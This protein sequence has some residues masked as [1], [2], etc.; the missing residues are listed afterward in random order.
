MRLSVVIPCYRSEGTLPTVVERLLT[1]LGDPTAAPEVTAFEVILVVDGS[2]DETAEVARA[3]SREHSMVRAVEL[4]RN[5]GQHNALL[6]GIARAQYELVVTMDDDLQHLPE[7]IPALV[8]PV[9]AGEADLVYGVSPVEEHGWWRSAASHAVKRALALAGVPNA[10]DV[11]AFRAF[12]TSLR[13]GF[14]DVTDPYNSLDVLLSWSTTS[15]RRVPVRMDRRAVGTSTYTFHG[16]V[17]HAVNMVT[18]Y[19]NL[20]LRAVAWLGGLTAATGVVLAAFVIWK[21]AVGETTVAGY[22]TIG[23]MVAMFSGAQMLSLGVIGE[24]LGRMHTRSMGKPVY[25]VRSDTGEGTT[26]GQD[27]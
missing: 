13:E 14:V 24:Y 20:P 23:A 9:A 10:L 6:A 2:P 17:R 27:T 8:A 5:Y 26:R 25:V 11:S 1:T 4:Q 15:V 7:E 18:G 12:R 22:T 16:L 19:S 3:S 21:F